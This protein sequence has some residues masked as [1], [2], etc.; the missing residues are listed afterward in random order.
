MQPGGRFRPL[1][2]LGRGSMGVVYR[3]YDAEME[4]D[5]AL[6]TLDGLGPDQLYRLKQEFR[7]LATVTHPNLVQLHDL[8]VS[9]A[10]AFFTME[11]VDGADF[12]AHVRGIGG[13]PRPDLERLQ[14]VAPQLVL[15]IAALHAAGKLHRDVKPSNILVSRGSRVVVLD[16]GLAT[17]LEPDAEDDREAVTLAGSPAYMA[18]EQLWGAPAAPAAD[19]YGIGVV[20]YEAL[21]GRLPFTGS[22]VDML[23]AK[24]RAAVVPL[25]HLVPGVPARLSA[26]VQELLHP[27][28]AHRPGPLDILERLEGGARGRR[29]ARPGGQLEG[30][31][32]PF[33]GRDAEL[34]RLRDALQRVTPGRPAVVHVVGSSGIGKSELVRRFCA[35]L[36]LEGRALVLRGR[37]HPQEAVPFEAVDALVDG[38]SRLLRGTPGA[39]ALADDEAA[40]VVRLFPVLG[41]VPALARTVPAEAGDPQETRRRGFQA[42]RSL[43]AALGRSRPLVLWIDDLQW[44]DLDSAALLRELLRPPDGPAV[45]LVVSYR[46]EERERPL[47]RLFQEAVGGAD[48]LEVEPLDPPDAHT[49]VGLLAPGG[50]DHETQMAVAR[51]AGGSPFLIAELTRHLAT[52]PTGPGGRSLALAEVIADRLAQL[53]EPARE[54]MELVSVAGGPLERSVVLAAAQLGEGGRPVVSALR[55]ACLLRSTATAER[56]AVELYHDRLRDVIL[57]SLS[58]GRRRDRHRAL[59]ATLSARPDPDPEALFQHCLGAGD[60]RQA[61]GWAAA[62]AERA[63]TALAFGRAAE[64]YLHALDLAGEEGRPAALLARLAEALANAGRGREAADRFLEAASRADPVSDG[65][66]LLGWRHRAAEQYLRTGHMDAGVATTREVLAAVGIRVPRTPRAAIATALVQRARVEWRRLRARPYDPGRAPAAALQRLDACWGAAIAV[67]LVDQ[68]LCEALGARHLV[69]ALD[70]GEPSRLVRALGFE[71]AREASFGGRFLRRRSHRLLR[72]AA[73]LARGSTDP[74]DRAWLDMA[75]GTTAY[76]SA[77]WRVARRR[78]DA[79]TARWRA[80][81]TGVVWEIVSAEAFALSALAHMGELAELGRRLPAAMADADERGDVYAAVGFRTGVP[82]MHWLARDEA[83]AAREAA[84]AAI[85]RW[86]T[87]G[88][89]VQHYLHLLA[90]AQASLYLDEPAAAWERVVAAWPALRRAFLLR[91]ESVGVELHHLRGRV[92]LAGAAAG[93]VADR[94]ARQLRDLAAREA[95]AIA[96][97]GVPTAAP[98]ALLLEAGVARLRG[99]DEGAA[100]LLALAAVRLRRADMRLYAAAAERAAGLLRRDE[101]GA[102]AVAAADAWMRA[103][104]I[105]RPDAMAAMLVPGCAPA[106]RARVIDCAA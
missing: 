51:E 73:R 83:G 22:A 33:V 105:R 31:T 82:A 24:E 39:L 29:A 42:L 14:A 53:P 8:V 101:S 99:A 81:C 16:F 15:G 94:K 106:A 54:V 78:C 49:L 104:G 65:A 25:E 102:R 9:E 86:P 38:L 92:A 45:L 6:K 93:G 47:L 59:A 26:L 27:D 46:S 96:R 58:G 63:A 64:L 13:V 62:A 89:H 10:Q 66:R 97:C 36:E 34:G 11:L 95:R 17:A 77:R 75:V 87:V 4:Q 50:V 5:V 32:R 48:H 43:C 21:T 30:A 23:R 84:D 35:T 3:A 44:G 74:Y 28:A 72:T 80:R 57:A 12:V 56:P 98:F 91:M 103:Q 79:A 41:R 67:S 88:F 55:Q 19:W 40:A 18:P 90:A 68:S 71:A 20:F 100:T 85:G 70:L 1:A 52:R 76:M 60:A 7:V 37:C 61:A 2:V 69:E